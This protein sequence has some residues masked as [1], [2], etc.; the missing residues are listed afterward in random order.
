MLFFSRR[1]IVLGA[2]FKKTSRTRC[3]SSRT[4][5]RLSI[6]LCCWSVNANAFD[7]QYGCERFWAAGTRPSELIGPTSDATSVLRV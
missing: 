3:Q 7:T 1:A 2:R 4:V 6:F 5:A